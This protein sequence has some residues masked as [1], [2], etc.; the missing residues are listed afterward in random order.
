MIHTD[1]NRRE[2]LNPRKVAAACGLSLLLLFGQTAPVLANPT[3][4]AVVAGSATIGAAGSTLTINQSSHNAIIN[5][6]Q[7]SIASGE[8]TKFLVP[9][10]SSATLNRVLGGNPSA[11]YGNLQ[12]NGIVYLV[13]PNGIVVG[14]SGQID[15]ASFLASTLDVSNGQFLKGGSL[16]FAGDSGASVDNEG[17]IEAST[18]NVYLIANQV[19]NGGT[20][21]AAHGSAGLAAG[22]DVLFQ[23]AGSQHLFE[24]PVSPM[25]EPS[26][27]RP[28]NWWRPAEMPTR[29]PST[30]PVR[31]PPRVTR[32]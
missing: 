18:G 32:K 13:N 15:T 25:R 26:G 1:S 8:L 17:T 31:S 7:F 6:R 21:S 28:R 5:W 16:Q 3:G 30:T 29:W 11:I 22:S 4:G 9:N 2:R 14:P 23:Q 12:S 19:H 20:L 24:R 27:P 10:S